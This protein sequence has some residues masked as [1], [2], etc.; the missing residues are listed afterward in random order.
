MVLIRVFVQD[1]QGG[2]PVPLVADARGMDTEA[3]R[4]VARDHGYESAFI[5]PT[6]RPD[7][8][9][10]LRYFVPLHEME[11]CGHA[12]VGALWALRQWGRWATAQATVEAASGVVDA[13]WEDDTGTVWISQPAVRTQP[14]DAAARQAVARV[15]RLPDPDGAADAL[16]MVNA[17]TSRMKTLVRLPDVRTLNALRPDFAAIESVCEAIGSTGLYP[18]A[19]DGEGGVLAP[20]AHARQFP[21]ASGYPEDAATGI[22]ASAL[23]GYLAGQGIIDAGTAANPVTCTIRQGQA[24]GSPSA[25]AVRGRW[26]DSGA[27]AGCMLG[28]QVMW[29]R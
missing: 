10:R 1:G 25:I 5:L 15:L 13:Q 24:M 28:G 21:K 12:T 23:W 18:Y 29:G 2:N 17:A 3:M 9:L 26:S 22:A 4:A 8:D 27:A 19:F 14:L 11:M 7:C 16:D 20:T 6:G